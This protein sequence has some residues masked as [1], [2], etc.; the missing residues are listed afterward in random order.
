[1]SIGDVWR[2][3]FTQVIDVQPVPYPILVLATGLLAAALVVWSP[4]WRAL[5][6]VE[7]IVHEGGHAAA[8]ALTG[9]RLHGVRLH[10]D[11]S[12]L[13]VSSGR[14]TGPGRVF[15]VIAGYPASAVLGLGGVALLRTEHAAALLWASVVLLV[16]M[17]LLIRNLY[18]VVP[19]VGGPG[20]TG[21]T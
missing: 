6:G 21:A 16:A 12:G 20:V 18:G 10:S 8:A 3:V 14:P 17:L 15:T 13:T 7:T 9:R 2:R 5:R 11:T 1:M 19:V 4:S